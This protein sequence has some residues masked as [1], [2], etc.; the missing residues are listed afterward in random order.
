[1]DLQKV[2]VCMCL[3]YCNDVEMKIVTTFVGLVDVVET[4]GQAVFDALKLEPETVGLDLCA[5]VGFA[6]DGASAMVGQLPYNSVW[7]RIRKVSLNCILMKFV[8]LPLALCAEHGFE[9]M[10]SNLGFL[11]KEIPMWFSKSII[12]KEK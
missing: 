8:C 10:P 9:K 4:T 7:S 12:K 2:C 1:M 11:L 5:C 6:S 3:R